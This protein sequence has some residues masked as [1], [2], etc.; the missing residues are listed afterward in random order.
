M[1]K[2]VKPISPASLQCPPG[3]KGLHAVF[4]MAR[5]V[6][7]L[8]QWHHRPQIRWQWSWPSTRGYPGYIRSRYIYGK[9]TDQRDR[10]RDR[11]TSVARPLRRK[12]NTTR[13]T[14]PMEMSSVLSTSLTEGAMV[15]SRTTAVSM[16]SGIDALITGK[17][18]ADEV[19]RVNDIGAGLAE[20]DD[21]NRALAVQIS[22][23]TDVSHTESVT[24]ATSDRRTA[25]RHS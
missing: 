17:L 16:P 5:I 15:N 13:M 9:G 25:S 14:S 19:D 10:H 2:T 7:R 1:V 20:D 21:L 24:S 11:G 23:S 8:P 18:R 22:G 4:Q 12:T 3:G 6:P